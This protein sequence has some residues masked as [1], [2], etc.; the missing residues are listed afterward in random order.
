MTKLVLQKTQKSSKIASSLLEEETEGFFLQDYEETSFIF[1][2][3]GITAGG[4][5]SFRN[6]EEGWDD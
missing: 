5:E 2:S 3:L 1:Q 4:N 6:K